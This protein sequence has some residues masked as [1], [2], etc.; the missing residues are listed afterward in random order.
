LFATEFAE[1]QLDAT[2]DEPVLV[3]GDDLAHMRLTLETIQDPLARIGKLAGL[4]KLDDDMEVYDR[5]LEARGDPVDLTPTSRSK[6]QRW[7]SRR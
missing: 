7:A 1:A 2:D 4:I 3:S 5:Y 6:W